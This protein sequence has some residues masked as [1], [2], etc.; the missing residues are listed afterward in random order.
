MKYADCKRDLGFCIPGFQVYKVYNNELIK[1][2]KDYGKK[3]DKD[4][5]VDGKIFLNTRQVTNMN[6]Y[7]VYSD[8]VVFE[9]RQRFLQK[10][11]STN[12]G[13]TVAHPTLGTQPTKTKTVFLIDSSSLRRP[14][15]ERMYQK[16]P[17]VNF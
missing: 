6:L 13:V 17:K 4:S 15:I 12:T 11:D 8:Q 2:G 7:F 10:L 16:K 1:Y 5:A 14:T 3:L 9:R